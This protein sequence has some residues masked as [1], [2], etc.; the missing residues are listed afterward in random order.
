MPSDFLFGLSHIC[1]NKQSWQ[2]FGLNNISCYFKMFYNKKS[3]RF[4]RTEEIG[5]IHNVLYE[6]FI[7]SRYCDSRKW[8]IIFI[9]FEKTCL[10]KRRGGSN[11]APLRGATSE[12][13][14][15]MV[16][17]A[18]SSL[19]HLWR[20]RT[21]S[22]RNRIHC[23]SMEI[24]IFYL[25]QSRAGCIRTIVVVRFYLLMLPYYI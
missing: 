25:W 18:P 11:K 6:L 16:I 7:C 9:W 19:L 3:P 1:S 8:Y 10:S 22:T 24:L 20:L 14:C 5:E 12:Y 4:S 15:R 21:P 17:I 2:L 23:T 13:N